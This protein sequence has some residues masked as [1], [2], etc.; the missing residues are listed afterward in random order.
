[1]GNGI[2][3]QPA[4]FSCLPSFQSFHIVIL[5]LDCAGKTTVLYRL[6]FNEFVNTVPTKGF[7]TE[8]MK[9]SSTHQ[10]LPLF[11]LRTSTLRVP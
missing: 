8:K 10:T 5:G 3:D 6:R 2:S 11:S 4:I 7:N 1:M 9:I